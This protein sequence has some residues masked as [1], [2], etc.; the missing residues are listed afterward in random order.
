MQRQDYKINKI[1][2]EEKNRHKSFVIWLT[3]LSGAGKSTIANLLEQFFFEN[4]IRSYVL[5]G[6]NVRMGLNKDLD[7]SKEGRKENIRRIAEVANL[8]CDAGIVTI[9]AFISPYIDD[10][11]TAGAVIGKENFLEIFLDASVDSCM[12]R[13]VKGLYR[14]AIEGKIENF[15]G[16]SDVYEKPV[17]PFLHLHTDTESPVDSVN[18]IISALR[19]NKLIQ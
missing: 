4:N 13:D 19:E 10:R 2:R 8:F 6:D 15:T 7:F 16:I 14:K 18:R 3:G 1:H 17:N 9:T 12:E 11:E 5:D